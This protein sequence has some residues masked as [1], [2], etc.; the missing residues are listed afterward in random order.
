MSPR[1]H[2]IEASAVTLPSL[3]PMEREI[4]HVESNRI[5]SRIRVI[6]VSKMYKPSAPSALYP[7][8]P[9]R[10]TGLQGPPPSV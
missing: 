9:H 3:C 10:I 2:P 1:A 6:Q 4:P 7:R 8:H 5:E